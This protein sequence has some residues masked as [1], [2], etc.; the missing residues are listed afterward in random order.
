MRN[1]RTMFTKLAQ[2]ILGIPDK[3][4]TYEITE[5]PGEWEYSAHTHHARK[6]GT[7][8][9]V[10]LSPNDKAHSWAVRHMPGPG[11]KVLAVI[12]PTHS[13]KYMDF[14]GVIPSGYGAGTV[15]PGPRGKADVVEASP[16]RITYNIHGKR[17]EE[18]NLIRPKPGKNW[19]LVNSST[20]L[21]KYKKLP[22]SKG[23][24]KELPYSDRMAQMEGVLQP[25]VDGA[26]SL[27]I[28]EP[29]KRPRV[30]SY[31]ESKRGQ[32]LEYTHKIPGLFNQ[33]VPAGLRA[34]VRGETVLIDPKGRARPSGE[35]AGLLNSS[36]DKA[37]AVQHT[38]HLK[39][40]PFDILGD[41]SL[42]HE[43]LAKLQQIARTFNG[44]IE[45]EGAISVDDKK[46]LI[47][48]IKAGNHP[49]TQEGIVLHTTSGP[50]RAKVIKDKDVILRE[51]LEGAGKHT[52][53]MG[54]YTYSATPTGKILGHVG[55][56]FSDKDREQMWKN[57][58]A[59]QGVTMRVAYEK[60]GK[61]GALYA[62]RHKHLGQHVDKNIG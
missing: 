5:S 25:K 16:D 3:K 23:D 32:V 58:K 40:M 56:G 11:E 53:R 60:A 49:L 34:I 36:T 20:T 4:K 7:H 35:T 55:T 29:H 38:N 26:H 51:I 43:R 44:L 41:K 28:L 1:T 61:S 52:G 59:L 6:A 45:P 57:R 30:F 54:S 31:R 9:D 21:D 50:V 19:L 24:Y 39:I 12:Q 46:K 33:R 14:Q 47:A 10:R 62:A 27:L 15:E 13:R 42:P 22:K 2:A 8:I 37:R 18:Y 48:R 17:T